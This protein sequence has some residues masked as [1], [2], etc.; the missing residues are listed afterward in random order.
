MDPEKTNTQHR[1]CANPRFVSKYGHNT[2]VILSIN[3]CIPC[4]WLISRQYCFLHTNKA[5]VLSTAVWCVSHRGYRFSK[6][7]RRQMPNQARCCGEQHYVVEFATFWETWLDHLLFVWTIGIT[8]TLLSCFSC[9]WIFR[10]IKRE[11]DSLMN[12]TS[13]Y[14]VADIHVTKC[15]W[16][17][18]K[19]K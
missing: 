6:N 8:F 18:S 5:T 12:G 2:Q 9:S 4:D 1:D 11:V 19:I 3:A 17:K 14:T 13:L 10:R 7:I 15:T 16:M